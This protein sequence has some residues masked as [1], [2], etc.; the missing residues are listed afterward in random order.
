MNSL[1]FLNL[2]KLAVSNKNSGALKNLEEINNSK[3]TDDVELQKWN[4][5]MAYSVLTS[6]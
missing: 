6:K 4:N 5:C 2:M 3:N 1:C